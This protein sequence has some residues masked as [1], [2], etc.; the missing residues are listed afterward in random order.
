MVN[1]HFIRPHISFLWFESCSIGKIGARK[2]EILAATISFDGWAF[3][4]ETWAYL[5][6]VIFFR[7]KNPKIWVSVLGVQLVPLLFLVLLVSRVLLVGWLDHPLMHSRA[8]WPLLLTPLIWSTIWRLR[9]A[10][11]N[12]KL[13]GYMG[14]KLILLPKENDSPIKR[15]WPHINYLLVRIYKR[16]RRS[17]L[18]L[19]GMTSVLW[20]RQRRKH[21]LCEIPITCLPLST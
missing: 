5:S 15:I 6:K 21:W 17:W 10:W 20:L 19:L 11:V 13:L 18:W 3:E 14:P 16:L 1:L 9:R 8:S 12:L 2:K 4:E 7:E